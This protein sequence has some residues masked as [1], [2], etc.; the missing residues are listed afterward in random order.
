MDG[1]SLMLRDPAPM[2]AR[3]LQ[4]WGGHQALWL[5]AYGSLLWKRDF[6][7]AEHRSARV[8]G[9]HRAFRMRSRVNRGSAQE[10]GLVFALMPG[11]ACRGAVFRLPAEAAEATLRGLWEREMPTGVYDPRWLVCQTADGPVAAL[12]FTL[13]RHSPAHTGHLDD[14]QLLHVLRHARGRYGSTL[15]YLVQTAAALRDQGIRDAE[16]QRLVALAGRHGL[17]PSAKA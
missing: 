6:E 8:Q 11:G 14:T 2:L 5:F 7:V 4:A 13:A 12:A 1:P 9:W 15:D 3:T 17:V 16:V 10:P